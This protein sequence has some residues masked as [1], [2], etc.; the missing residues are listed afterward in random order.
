MIPHSRKQSDTQLEW[1]IERLRGVTGKIVKPL[2]RLGIHT[3]Q[4][5]LFHIPFR[6]DD[7]SKTIPIKDV[8]LGEQVTITGEV[9]SIENIKT[10]KRKM[11]I[12]QASIADSTGTISAVWF[13]QPFLAQNIKVGRIINISGKTALSR[14][15]GRGKLA[16]QNPAYEIASKSGKATHTGRLVPIY[17]ET[18]GITSRWLRYLIRNALAYVDQMEDILLKE[19]IK[20]QQLVPLSTAIQQIHFPKTAKEA[21]HAR[22]RL[23][24]E[25]LFFIQL[26]VLDA[27]NNIKKTKAPTIPFDLKNVKKCLEYVS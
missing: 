3:I 15:G 21:E 17:P 4:D 26:L 14:L 22:K 7:F 5:L 19:I 6:Y 9:Q 20:R 27:K 11:Y 16:I 10:W 2:S 18:Q 24:F 13:N 23:A 8:K 12:T 25:E 1:P